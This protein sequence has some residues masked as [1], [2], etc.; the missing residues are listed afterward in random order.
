MIIT[1][2]DRRYILPTQ[3]TRRQQPPAVRHYVMIRFLNWALNDEWRQ[4]IHQ[5]DIFDTTL[6]N[7]IAYTLPSLNNQTCKNFEIVLLCPND[8]DSMPWF[9][10]LNHIESDIKIHIVMNKQLKRFLKER[11]TTSNDICITSR[12]DADDM[13]D[14]GVVEDIQKQ[15]PR[16]DCLWYGYK[17]KSMLIKTYTSPNTIHEWNYEGTASIMQNL[18]CKGRFENIYALGNH[19]HA[20]RNMEKFAKIKGYEWEFKLNNTYLDYALYNRTGNNSS[21]EKRVGRQLNIPNG[22]IL[23]KYGYEPK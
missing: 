12:I 9:D 8:K 1:S 6:R 15:T 20:K 19:Y 4:K 18:I 2:N 10:E 23:R 11:Y 7:F 17:A 16:Y 3:T 22:E 13:I 14:S 21:D 5:K